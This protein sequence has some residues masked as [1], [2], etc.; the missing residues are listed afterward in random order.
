MGFV[1]MENFKHGEETVGRVNSG[2]TGVNRS[3][4]KKSMV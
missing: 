1:L 2:N 3:I 4:L